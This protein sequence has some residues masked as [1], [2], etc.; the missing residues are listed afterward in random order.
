MNERCTTFSVLNE[1][2]KEMRRRMGKK[3]RE[4]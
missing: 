3:E 2:R 4:L 1:K